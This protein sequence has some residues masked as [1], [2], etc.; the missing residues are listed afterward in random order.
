MLS[1]V[2]K[3]QGITQKKKLP[4][5]TKNVI[6]EKKF[7]FGFLREIKTD[8]MYI[9]YWCGI[10]AFA[11]EICRVTSVCHMNHGVFYSDTMLC[12]PP[13]VRKCHIIRITG[14]LAWEGGYVTVTLTH[15]R[16]DINEFLINRFSGTRTQ[17][18]HTKKHTTF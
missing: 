11:E 7:K 12:P 9:L 10:R 18:K 1:N 3:Y 5:R 4:E 14:G 17:K 6:Q 16:Q 13:F 2:I 15:G 8:D